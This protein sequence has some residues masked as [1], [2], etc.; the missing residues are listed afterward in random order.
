VHQERQ[1]LLLFECRPLRQLALPLPQLLQPP[2]PRPLELIARLRQL[3]RVLRLLL[4]AHLAHFHFAHPLHCL[5]NLDP[6]PLVRFFLAL[7]QT[8]LQ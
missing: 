4:Q 3:L 8:L 2:L 5:L 6:D 1:H 7:E